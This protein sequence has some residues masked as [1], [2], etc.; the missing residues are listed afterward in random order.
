MLF[1]VEN[2]DSIFVDKKPKLIYQIYKGV[3]MSGI[4]EQAREIVKANGFADKSKY[5]S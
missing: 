2:P 1:A 5:V 4:I 3:D